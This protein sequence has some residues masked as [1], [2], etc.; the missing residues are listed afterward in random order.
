KQAKEFRRIGEI[1]EMNLLQLSVQA[2]E[3]NLAVI[4]AQN[5]QTAAE[6]ELLALLGPEVQT[7]G[8][9]TD[10]LANLL[11]LNEMEETTFLNNI[12]SNSPQI[13]EAQAAVQQKQ[14][15]ICL[16]QS[17]AKSNVTLGGGVY[18]DAEDERSIASANVSIPIRF[19]DKNQG[20]IMRAQAEYSAAVRQ[21]EQIELQ[22]RQQC[23]QIYQTYKTARQE[24]LVYRDSVLPSLKKSY[25]MK[26]QA[27][28]Q[29]QI[30]FLEISNSQITYF[31]ASAKY[32][33]SQYRLAEAI[34]LLEGMLLK[35][36]NVMS[37]R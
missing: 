20:N 29:A 34:T 5:R 15:I 7:I 16:E 23:S 31:E 35:S 30:G 24:S 17:R 36:D 10:S 18:Y 3:A 37:L 22:L 27:F 1:S 9:I 26:F 28:K 14:A 21:V 4:A 19:Y 33:E 32:I 11:N 25:E 13:K 8:P 6:R 12:I 2:Q